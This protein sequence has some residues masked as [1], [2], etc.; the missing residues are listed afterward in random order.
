MRMTNFPNPPEI[1]SR[2]ISI[3]KG[4]TELEVISVHPFASDATRGTVTVRCIA[5]PTPSFVG[6]EFN[7]MYAS[8]GRL[9][10]YRL[11]ESS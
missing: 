10:A 7:H 11:K 8:N 5:S 2:W 6:R 3:A 1:G 9:Y 4:H